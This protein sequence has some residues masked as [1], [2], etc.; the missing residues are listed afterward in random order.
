MD[1]DINSLITSTIECIKSTIDSNTI[2]GTPINVDNTTIIPIT[3]VSIGFV[4]GG[5]EIGSKYNKPALP[6][7]GASTS[8]F[9][10]TPVG[11]I[12]IVNNVIQYQ[13]IVEESV[14]KK[15]IELIINSVNK[16]VGENDEK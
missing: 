7:A 15:L 4:T 13:S 14:D 9:N 11:F 12:S 3:K 5:G 8:G 1:K 6:F 16:I 2:I 10:L